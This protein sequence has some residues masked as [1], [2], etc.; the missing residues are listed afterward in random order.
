MLLWR[1]CPGSR[2]PLPHLLRPASARFGRPAATDPEELNPIVPASAL[3]EHEAGEVRLPVLRPL[4]V[5]VPRS[6]GGCLPMCVR[7]HPERKRRAPALPRAPTGRR[8]WRRLGLDFGPSQAPGWPPRR[9]GFS[10]QTATALVAPREQ[11]P[12]TT[13]RR[14]QEWPER[15]PRAKAGARDLVHGQTRQPHGRPRRAPLSSRPRRFLGPGHSPPRPLT[16]QAA[17]RAER[18]LQ[19]H[20]L[21]TC[22]CP[23][24][25]HTAGPRSR[26]RL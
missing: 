12:S 18:R 23:P 4:P 25:P 15:Q 19:P 17:V 13:R 20:Q 16:E 1:R 7:P 14:D 21:Y 26:A 24:R 22:V 6:D 3:A 2:Q 11:T 10:T 8:S 9:C 5:E